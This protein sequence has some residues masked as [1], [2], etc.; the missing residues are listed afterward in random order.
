[1]LA[2]AGGGLGVL[3]AWWAGRALA[4]FGV[5]GA[6]DPGQLRLLDRP[7]RAGVCAGRVSIATAVLFGLAPAWSASK[8]RARAGAQG[9]DGGRR[10]AAA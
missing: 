4:G 5:D 7:H 2:A 6:A 9:N 10:R 1:M 8:P 3:M